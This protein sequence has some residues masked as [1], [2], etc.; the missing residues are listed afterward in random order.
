MNKRHAYNADIFVEKIKPNK[1]IPLTHKESKKN[2]N[3]FD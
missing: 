3:W 2:F 1:Q